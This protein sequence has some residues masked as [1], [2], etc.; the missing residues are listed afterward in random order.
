MAWKRIKYPSE[1]VNIGDEWKSK[2]SN[3][4]AKR[5]RVSLGLK[6]LGSD[7]WGDIAQRYP[8]NSQTRRAKSPTSPTTAPSSKSKTAWKAWYNVSEMDWTKQKT[9]TR[10]NS[11][12]LARKSMS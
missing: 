10:A 4:T 11:S 7:P 2:S 9:S 5:A 6:Q 1:V 12:P 8:V 3:S